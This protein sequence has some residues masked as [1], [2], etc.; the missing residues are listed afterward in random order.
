MVFR[1][2]GP[3]YAVER[4]GDS[5]R[6][7]GARVDRLIGRHDLENEEALAHIERTL[8]RMGVIRELEQQGFEAGQDVEIAGVVFDLDP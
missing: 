3:G 6:V 2:G 5:W 1:P 4:I 7:S 8:R